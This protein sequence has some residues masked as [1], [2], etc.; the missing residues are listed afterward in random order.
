MAVLANDVVAA[1]RN[2]F[3]AITYV[4][5]HFQLP[6]GTSP[7]PAGVTGLSNLTCSSDFE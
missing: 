6:A 4:S 1:V 2:A 3:D 5:P 7:Q